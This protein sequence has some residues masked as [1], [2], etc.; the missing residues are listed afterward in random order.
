M[1][2]FIEHLLSIYP[3]PSTG[4][5]KIQSLPE[6]TYSL[7]E[8]REKVNKE[9][10]KAYIRHCRDTDESSQFFFLELG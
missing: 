10:Y 7:V 8:D 5:T 3:V 2:I 6:E 9:K 1:L 4:D